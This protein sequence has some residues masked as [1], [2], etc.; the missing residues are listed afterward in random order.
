MD[1]DFTVQNEG[2]IVLLKPHTPEASSWAKEH[3]PDDCPTWGVHA[4]VIE[5]RFIEDIVTGAREAG[6]TVGDGS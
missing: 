4:F 1:T 2:S 3:L 5:H 6:L